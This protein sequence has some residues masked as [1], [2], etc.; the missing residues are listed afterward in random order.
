MQKNSSSKFD[1]IHSEQLKTVAPQK[2]KTG[3]YVETYGCFN[4]ASTQVIRETA[5]TGSAH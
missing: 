2:P 5:K 3:H 4:A 1:K